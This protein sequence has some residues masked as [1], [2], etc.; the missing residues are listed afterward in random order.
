MKNIFSQKSN[1]FS[2]GFWLKSQTNCSNRIND[3]TNLTT[4]RYLLVRISSIS[5]LLYLIWF[6]IKHLD[7]AIIINDY[8]MQKHGFLERKT[9]HPCGRIKS[10]VFLSHLHSDVDNKMRLDFM[11]LRSEPL[12]SLTAGEKYVSTISTNYTISKDQNLRDWILK[13]SHHSCT[14]YNL[15][16][17]S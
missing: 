1:L 8:L 12:W 4:R 7:H 6:S 16:M 17:K 10:F 9:Q 3:K 5:S 13:S 15:L 11:R 14:F 2:F